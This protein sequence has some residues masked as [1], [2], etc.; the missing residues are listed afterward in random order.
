MP[1]RLRPSSRRRPRAA[2]RGRYRERP[3][4]CRRAAESFHVNSIVLDP[5]VG[6]EL[7]GGLL[8]RG[9]GFL[10]AASLDLDVEHLAL[11]HA[12]HAGDA[13]RFERTLDRLALGIEDAGFERDGDARFHAIPVFFLIGTPPPSIWPESPA[14]QALAAQAAAAAATCPQRA[15]FRRKPPQCTGATACAARFQA[16]WVP[17]G[18]PESALTLRS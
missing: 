3:R 14:A 18:R 10:A 16:K 12:G 2:P 6:E 8:Q 4:Q 5:G 7:V 1:A 9:L 13:E 17:V 15:K 11:A